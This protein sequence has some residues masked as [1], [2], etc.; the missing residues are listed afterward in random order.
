MNFI[1]KYLENITK[2]YKTGRAREHRYRPALKELLEKINPNILAT[3]EP[4]REKCWAPDFIITDKKNI[5]RWYIEAK[6]ITPNILNDNKNQAQIS[7]YFDGEL[8]YNF[9]HTDN[10]EFRFYRNAELVETV[11]I[12]EFSN[13]QIISKTEKFEKLEMLLKNFLTFKTQTI[14]SSKKLSEIMAWKARMIKTVIYMTLKNN[15][16]IKTEIHNQFDVFKK[17]LVH[18]LDETSF[19]DIYAQTI[20]YWLFTARLHDPTLPTFDRD[21]AARLLPKSNPFLKKT[22]RKVHRVQILDYNGWG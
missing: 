15:K 5:P 7:K 8:G 6:D 10:I 17:V 2:E 22:K 9:I 21:E 20:T 18:D 14:S 3:N 13:N 4:A 16:D 1:Q 11:K 19:A 12:A